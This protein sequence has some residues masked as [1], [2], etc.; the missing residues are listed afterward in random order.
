MQ[1]LRRSPTPPHPN[2]VVRWY[3]LFR[4]IG[5]LTCHLF[6]LD[7][8]VS[9][10][11]PLLHTLGNVLLLSSC[12]SERVS[13]LCRRLVKSCSQTLAPLWEVAGRLSWGL[14]TRNNVSDQ[15]ALG[16]WVQNPERKR[17]ECVSCY[18]ESALSLG[19]F[20]DKSMFPENT[21][22]QEWNGATKQVKITKALY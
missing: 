9:A 15:F 18:S 20:N 7:S 2:E 5:I 16:R 21:D 14:W 4:C 3:L 6:L 19:R 8:W 10:R 13:C 12:S 11:F 1:A 22:L 17:L